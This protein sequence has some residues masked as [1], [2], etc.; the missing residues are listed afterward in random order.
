MAYVDNARLQMAKMSEI[1][2]ENIRLHSL[3]C[4]EQAERARQFPT[5][6]VQVW[7]VF[8]VLNHGSNPRPRVC[9]KPLYQ[10][11]TGK[12]PKAKLI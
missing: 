2:F 3:M 5:G 7:I 11:A 6:I 10:Y 8:Q 9:G 12:L 1:C 4:T